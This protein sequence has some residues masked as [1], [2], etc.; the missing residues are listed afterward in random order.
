MKKLYLDCDGVILDTI[1]KSYQMLKEEGIT[2]EEGR[3]KFYSN[4]C[5]E[6]LIIESGEINNS[7][8]KIKELNKYYDIEILTHV[9]SE[10]EG[11]EKIKYFNKVLP[12]INVIIVPKEIKKADFV[13]ATNTVLVDDYS[14]NLE[15][16][17]EKGG[18]PVKF[19]DSHK[20]SE[21]D[22]ITDLLELIDLFSTNKIKIEE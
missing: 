9:H 21:F 14:P 1:N 13:E 19:S 20:E 5:W 22:V 8:S 4:I 3:K 2:T 15:Y 18:I 11:Q 10:K 7:I 12:G 6:T 16:W 17:K